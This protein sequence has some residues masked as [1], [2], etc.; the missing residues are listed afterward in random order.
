MIY[1]NILKIILILILICEYTDSKNIHSSLAVVS[2]AWVFFW[3]GQTL[4]SYMSSYAQ[5]NQL[6]FSDTTEIHKT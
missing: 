1:E 6:F 5:L 2:E 3:P 4:S